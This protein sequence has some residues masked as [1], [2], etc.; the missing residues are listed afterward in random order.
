MIWT[1]YYSDRSTFSNEDGTWGIAPALGVIAVL[2]LDPSGSVGRFMLHRHNFYYKATGSDECF[3]SSSKELI[4]VHVPA[5]RDNQI[6][7]G[8]NADQAVFWEILHT[9]GHDPAYPRTTPAR[10]FTDIDSR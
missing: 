1:I 2:N 10:R 4:R 7:T 5:I 3:G 9:A 8:G 6:K